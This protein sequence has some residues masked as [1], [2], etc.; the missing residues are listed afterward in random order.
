MS[1]RKMSAG[2][3]YIGG[4][5]CACG[6]SALNLCCTASPVWLGSMP[7]DACL[8]L[9]WLRPPPSPCPLVAAGALLWLWCRVWRGVCGGVCGSL[10]QGLEQMCGLE[11]LS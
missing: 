6:D 8:R 9:R 11:G 7:A 1:Y 2:C 5:A 4:F 10:H 3:V